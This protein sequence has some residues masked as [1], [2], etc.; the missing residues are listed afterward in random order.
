MISLGKNG[1]VTLGK[2]NIMSSKVGYH[3]ITTVGNEAKLRLGKVSERQVWVR[4]MWV[5]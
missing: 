4:E 3:K 2:G 5:A 1:Q